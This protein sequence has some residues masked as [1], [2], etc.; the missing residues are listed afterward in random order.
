MELK[1]IIFP[2]LL[3]VCMAGGPR[4]QAA[5]ENFQRIAFIADAHI[6]DVVG[7]PELVRSMEVQVQST[8]LFN[9]NYFALIAALEDVVKRGISL[10]VLPGDLTDDGQL[11]NQ[12]A[13]K[14]I[15]DEYACRHG[16]S[17]FV[18]TGNH[19][20]LRPFG[21]ECTRHDFLTPTGQTTA[22]TSDVSLGGKGMVVDTLLRSAGYREEMA[23][24]ARFGYFPQSAY[25]Y[26]ESPFCSY[27]YDTYDYQRALAESP[28]DKRCYLLCDSLVANDASYLVEPV[29]GLWLLAIDGSVYL[30]DGVKNGKQQYQGAGSGYNNVLKHK[31][32][33]LPWVRNVAEEAKHRNKTLV[34]FC[35]Y[36]LVDFNRGA[37]PL[38]EAYWGKNKFDL[39]R[40]PADSI[41]EAFWEACIRIHVAGHMHVNNT[42]VKVGKDGSRLYNIQVPSIATC[43]PA[44]K[45]LTIKDTNTFEVSTVLL[46]SVPGFNSL[47]PLYE[48]E[49]AYTLSSGKKPIWSKEALNSKSYAEFCDWQFKDLVRT[50]FVPNDLPPVLLDS[51]SQEDE[52]AQLLSD[53]VL[54]LYRLRYAGSLARK[55]IPNKRL[56]QY[57]E[58]FEEIKR[59]SVSS[60]FVQ[61]MDALERIFQR[62][63]E[64]E[65]DTDV[66]HCLCLP[67][68]VVHLSPRKSD[69]IWIES[70]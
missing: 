23:C 34:A 20:P 21:T 36:P 30:P 46:D 50:R 42:G 9:E 40:V 54:D 45:I 16:V 3:L 22:L 39:S 63:L 55:C 2:F 65:L 69:G 44:Y 1:R 66:I 15:L 8:R 5:C 59:Q 25:Y 11:V 53:L 48:K 37:S 70:D 14:R 67:E 57:Q 7:H 52:R 10:V 64:V 32:F 4:T 6:Q 29:K 61:Q 41:A 47:F 12:E 27:T 56:E 18:T 19:D 68:K 26:W 33:L 24:Y 62:F 58:M 28:I 31:P 51:L 17:F 49:Y 43:V 13:V 38:I 60:E 35:H